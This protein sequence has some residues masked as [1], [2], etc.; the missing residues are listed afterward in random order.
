MQS[1]FY[2]ALENAQA[3]LLKFPIGSDG[4]GPSWG[5]SGVIL[6]HG[7]PQ[8]EVEPIEAV[9]LGNDLYRLAEVEAGPFSSLRLRWG[10][11]FFADMIGNHELAIRQVKVPLCYQ[12][13]LLITSGHPFSDD[14]LSEVIHQ[15]S[16]GWEVMAGGILTITVPMAD[17]EAF[18][19]EAKSLGS[20]LQT[21][22]LR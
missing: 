12:H 21:S 6:D 1:P 3:Y 22:R 14:P 7:S 10:D 2:Q 16:G 8:M 18:E 13:Y 9:P 15:C 5:T 11:E 20:D 4:T 19:L 17:A